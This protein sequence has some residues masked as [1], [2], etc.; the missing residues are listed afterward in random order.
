MPKTRKLTM[1]QARDVR[2]Y[3]AAH[4]W[5]G[6]RKAIAKKYGVSYFVVQALMDGRT[7]RDISVDAATVSK[8]N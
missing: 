7:Y 2:L 5:H 6:A 4:K 3:L 8:E 1:E